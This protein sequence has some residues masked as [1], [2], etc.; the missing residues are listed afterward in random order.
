M[1]RLLVVDL[2]PLLYRGHFA[3]IRRPRMTSRGFNASALHFF[4]STLADLATG[5]GATHAALVMDSGPTF[6]HAL[7]PPYK[8]QR[9]KMPEDIAASIGPARDFAAAMRVPVLS[10]EGFEADDVA[11]TLAARAD[12]AGWEVWVVSPDKDMAQLVTDRVKLVRPSHV[13]GEKDD[14]YD[15]ARVCAEWGLS[16][17]AQMVDWLGMAGDSADNI[18]GFPGVGPKKASE[19]IAKFGS[20]QGVVDHASEIPGK[21]GQTIAA[22]AET[23]LLS[24]KLAEIRRDVPLETA[25]EDLA[26]RPFDATS[27][28][29][30]FARYEMFALSKRI[31]GTAPA[32]SLETSSL[33]PISPPQ[34]IPAP[35]S[36]TPQPI[37]APL[38]GVPSVPSVP[39]VPLAPSPPPPAPV[40]GVPLVPSVPSVPLAPS[41]SPPLVA[42][43]PEKVAALA[44]ELE[45]APRFAFSASAEGLRIATEPGKE[46]FVPVAGA[47]APA[48]EPAT[49]ELPLFGIAQPTPNTHSAAPKGEADSSPPSSPPPEDL[50]SFFAAQSTPAPPSATPAP[51][52]GVP[53]VSS[54]PSVPL[55]P[56]PTPPAPLAGVP[57]VPSVPSVPLAL[58]PFFSDPAKVKIGHDLKP[59]LRALRRLGVEAVG[60]FEDTMLA[61]YVLDPTR[62]H[63]LDAVSREVL[64]EEAAPTVATVLRLDSALSRRVDAE[65]AARAWREAENPLVPVLLDMEDFGVRIDLAALSRLSVSLGA[66]LTAIGARIFELAGEPFNV[67]SPKQLGEILFG[68]LGLQAGAKTSGGRHSTAE[69]VLQGIVHAHPIVREVLEWRAV[70]KLKSTYVDK[71]P[72][73]VSPEDGRVHTTFQQA[74]TETGR[75]SSDNPN[76]QNIPV[77]TERGKPIRAAF[78]A[79]PGCT[80]VSADYSQ[81]ELRVLASLSGD[82]ALV[83]AFKRGEDVHAATAARVFGIDIADVTR[84]QRSRCKQVSFGIVYG[85]SAFGLSQRLGIPRS[86]ADTLI[87][88]WFE[89]HP[90]VK[91]WI[92]ETKARARAEGFVSTLLG[93]RRPLRDIG[94]RN[95]TL[96][97]AAERIAVNTP[98]Q[99]PAADIAKLAMVRVHSALRDRGLAA[100]LVLQIYDELLLEVPDGEVAEVSALVRDAMENALPLSVPLAVDVGTGKN[101]LDAH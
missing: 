15:R 23:A 3:M 79:S 20:V 94:S 83:K 27:L 52:A 58:L 63:Y 71:L 77:R 68:K 87:K 16:E 8:A 44:A 97:A 43:T 36:S 88:T 18:P 78:V 24:R 34:P 62:R 7:Y 96:R 100:R 26:L 48:A 30:L 57:L 42:D 74:L 32:L 59:S 49:P 28:G 76:L 72:Q 19:L 25:L 38:E 46:W 17:P 101:W 45:A 99:G 10:A 39:S 6:R 85:I 40:E 60:P 53:L 93:R 51:L 69:E 29:D 31:L 2:M 84:E 75:L 9:E 61:H 13:P 86:D 82:E 64:G 56:R 35:S 1:P 14:V 90:G 12:G 11:G 37:P 41:P 5:R 98:V 54:V 21:T 81:V 70:S 22:S 33:P 65:G 80:L 66:E 92:D 50:F 73:C 91:R 47:D 55:A 89:A 67:D 4:A 95:G